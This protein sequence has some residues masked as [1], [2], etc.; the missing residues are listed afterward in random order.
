MSL[1]EVRDLNVWFD[2]EAGRE[3]HAVQGVSL[4]LDPGD[5]MGLVGESGCGKTTSILAVMGLLPSSASVAGQIL[6]GG[7][8]IMSHGEPTIRPHRWTEIA[9]VFQ[10]AMNA[11]NPVQRVAAQIVEP[12][13]RHGV[14]EGAAAERRAGELLELVGIPASTGA[15]YPHELSGGMRQRAAIAMALA[16]SPKIL[17]ADEPTTALDVMVQAQIL[18]LLTRLSDDLGLALV[19]VTHDLPIVAQVCERAAVMYAG[20]IVETGGMDGLFHDPRH[21]YTRLLFA[22]TPD[23]H[24][25]QDV[26]SIPGAPPRL[27]RPIDGCEFRER[28]DVAIDRCAVE[29]P[30][31]LGAGGSQAA[32]HVPGTRPV[33]ARRSVPASEPPARAAA[34]GQ[35]LL[36]VDRLV[37]GFPIRRGLVGSIRRE[38][39]RTVRAVDGVSFEVHKGEMVALVGE[40]GCGKTTTAH[41]VMHLL[42]PDSGTVRFDGGEIASLTPRRLR[43]LRRRMQMIY[44]DPYESL[45][46]RLRVQ[47]TIE[48]PLIVHRMG[49][50]KIERREHV[51]EAMRRAGLTPPEQYMTRYPHELSGG[52]R[53]R[54]AI[55]GSLVLDPELLVADEPVSMLDVSVRA[56]VLGLLD[57]LRR[58]GDMGILMITHDLSTAAH[59]ADR[60]IVMYLGRIVEE[61]PASEVI[62]RPQH[63]YTKALLSVVPRP[64]PR[65]HVTPQILVGETPN[66]AQLPP[67]CRFHPRC[68]VAEERCRVEDPAL[69]AVD[70]GHRAACVLVAEVG[71]SLEGG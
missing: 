55:A 38:P 57:E 56:G 59:F 42:E 29:R 2:L 27:D 33:A 50:T 70:R 60:I 25:R 19:L 40:S 37:K 1:L 43:P 68:P 65:E 63:P 45:D 9:M 26:V 11:L 6:L 22:A 58:T 34:D 21:P 53:Q 41:S 71:P 35:A 47:E 66:P 62:E 8:D 24:G 49:G 13:E 32:C 15:R 4:S 12:M 18:Q 46:P 14:E 31:L 17:L 7:R 51:M 5:R 16:C 69:V 48:E 54:V 67:G 61:G 30:E 23:L 20:R 10:G 44:Q 3:L 28:C 36:E 39:R 64:D 52:Q